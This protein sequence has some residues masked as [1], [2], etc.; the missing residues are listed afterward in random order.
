MLVG[1]PKPELVD[2]FTEI[3]W[4]TGDLEPAFDHLSD[5][6]IVLAS[7]DLTLGKRQAV[8]GGFLQVQLQEPARVV[9]RL[10]RHAVLVLP[11]PIALCGVPRLKPR[12]RVG[13]MG[14][15]LRILSGHP[16]MMPEALLLAYPLIGMCGR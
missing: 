5:E 1:H 2:R 11:V 3:E 15:E 6:P 4:P 10:D 14:V 12:Q 8:H 9:K 16:I 13:L 7:V